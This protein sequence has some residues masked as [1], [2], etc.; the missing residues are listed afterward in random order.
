MFKCIKVLKR[1]RSSW[2]ITGTI[3][4][5][6]K[7]RVCTL[8]SYQ[9]HKYLQ[10]NITDKVVQAYWQS[11]TVAASLFLELILHVH[12][13]LS[14]VTCYPTIEK[15]ISPKMTSPAVTPMAIKTT[16]I[17]LLPFFCFCFTWMA[18]FSKALLWKTRQIQLEDVTWD[19]AKLKWSYLWSYAKKRTG[20][21]V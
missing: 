6:H 10:T 20:T 12:Q 14:V 13:L 19:P 5:E 2:A 4:T 16:F 18:V 11:P 1:R 17:F 3:S 7:W 15:I 21:D 8:I 9:S